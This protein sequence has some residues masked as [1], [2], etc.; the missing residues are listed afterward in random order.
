MGNKKIVGDLQTS[1]CLSVG[2]CVYVLDD[3]ATVGSSDR[4]ANATGFDDPDLSVFATG[5][6]VTDAEGE[7]EKFRYSFPSLSG[8]FAMASQIGLELIDLR[9]AA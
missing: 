2:S 9:N 5:F 3:D 7:G 4:P 6:C 8:V 1:G